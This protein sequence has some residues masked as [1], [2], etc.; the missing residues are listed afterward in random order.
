MQERQPFLRIVESAEDF[1][2]NIW[3]HEES[4]VVNEDSLF[5]D[6]CIQCNASAGG[7]TVRKMVFWHS[8]ILLPLIFLSW[9]FYIAL[10][11]VFRRH[12]SI[13]VPLCTKHLWQ[14][15]MLTIVGLSSFP[16]AAWMLW[17]AVTESQP[18]L[19]LSGILSIIVGAIVL[20]WG[21]NPIWASSI[22]EGHAMIRGIHPDLVNEY[23][24]E[25]WNGLE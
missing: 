5:P 13:S 7:H 25:Q 17:L 24:W 4:L 19:I 16:V 18:S 22:H 3:I 11:L 2:R 8:P 1:H 6:K 23:Q 12:I 21:R 9:P 10:A 14:R 20:G 15:R